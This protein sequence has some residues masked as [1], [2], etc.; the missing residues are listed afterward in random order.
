MKMRLTG[1]VGR[2]ARASGA[3]VKQNSGTYKKTVECPKRRRHDRAYRPATVR[4]GTTIL[5]C[6]GKKHEQQTLLHRF[7][8]P[9]S[10]LLATAHGRDTPNVAPS[11]PPPASL[12]LRLSQPATENAV[13]WDS[14]K[15]AIIVCDMWDQH[16]CKSAS[17]RVNELAGPINDMLKAAT[18]QGYVR[19]SRTKHL[20]RFLQ[21]Y[22][23]TQASHRGPFRQDARSAGNHRT[24]G[25]RLELARR[26]ARSGVTYR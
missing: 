9:R 3:G 19:D 16:W 11:D 12:P 23:A 21:E 17:A 7:C 25:H 14:K 22:A 8:P 20:H 4:M 2:E 6:N 26:Q 10:G 5:S 13:S 24:L 18:S 15:T 1:H